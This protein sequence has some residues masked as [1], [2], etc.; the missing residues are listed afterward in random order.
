MNGAV[1]LDI[2]KF[3]LIYLLLIIV[4][5]I[6]KKCQV[7]QTKL[8]VVASMRMTVQLVMAGLILTY[9]F[10]NPHPVFTVTY[11]V[12]MTARLIRLNVATSGTQMLTKIL[13]RDM[14][15]IG[16]REMRAVLT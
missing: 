1:A 14:L 11:I 4:L 16:T 9:I 12:A 10:E 6:M 7:N 5:A 3:A 2:W 8:L 13:M 15:S